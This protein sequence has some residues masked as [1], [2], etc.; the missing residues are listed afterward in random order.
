MGDHRS[1]IES[2]AYRHRIRQTECG[3]VASC[4]LLEQLT[5]VGETR[6]VEVPIDACQACC[7]CFPPST[8][9]LNPVVASLL[10]HLTDGVTARGGVGSCGLGRAQELH[11]WAELS[12][13]RVRAD[14]EDCI[15]PARLAR[16]DA[17][18]VSTEVI[19]RLLPVP[20]RR[21]G[22]TVHDWAVA[23]TTA[24]RRL[25]TLERCVESLAAAGWPEPTLFVDGEM[26]IPGQLGGLPICHRRPSVGAFPNYFLS[27]AELFM[28][29]PHADAYLLLQDDAVFP[30]VSAVR[31]YLESM[32]WPGS[33]GSIVSLYCG[34]EYTRDTPGWHRCEDR[35][36]WGA[37]AF[38]FSRQALKQ[39]L[40]SKR[41]LRHRQLPDDKGLSRID[42]LIGY[43]ANKKGIPIYYPS[44]SLVQHIGTISTI[45]DVARA[46]NLRRADRFIGDMF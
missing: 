2:C 11:A 4:G 6:L 37:V 41:V 17:S 22:K 5:D 31:D 38:V 44:P 40:T 9:D 34:A 32:L 43:V 13:P 7:E 21:C 45:W 19:Q 46:V 12:L 30:P 10:F 35:W 8:E 29:E 33:K 16:P 27:M 26:E 3:E 25:A 14:E 23:V 28:R 15:D 39:L 1:A 42:V 20:A 24:P 18:H 36:V